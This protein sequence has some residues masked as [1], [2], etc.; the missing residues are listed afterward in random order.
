MRSLLIIMLKEP[1]MG[2][3][4][5]RLAAG[6]GGAAATQFARMAARTA[7][8]RLGR[9]RRWRIVLAVTPDA[10]AASRIWPADLQ[11]VGQG[12]G[13]LGARMERLLGMRFRP[14]ILVGADIPAVTAALVSAA[15]KTLRRHDAVFGPA[16]DGGY[17]L[18]GLNRSAPRGGIF[19][20]VRWSTPFALADTLANL[21][22][23]RIGF[24]ARLGDVDDA[25]SHRRWGHLAGRVILPA[26]LP[27]EA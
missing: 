6:T 20:H 22:G 8:R 23:A 26:A 4:K 21:K 15:F 14:A 1:V 18:I 2:R 16:E 19:A 3:V 12:R 24:A 27:A 5:T 10:S 9:D 17:W 13:D 11:R 25:E 7:V